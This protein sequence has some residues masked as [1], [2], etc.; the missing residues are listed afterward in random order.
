MASLVLRQP[1][2]LKDK[3]FSISVEGKK[4]TLKVHDVISKDEGIYTCK[5][6]G[7]ETSGKLYVARTSHIYFGPNTQA[8]LHVL[9][10]YARYLS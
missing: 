3:K 6:Q 10:L 8:V 5:V 1:I 9:T 2:N 4:R 7:K